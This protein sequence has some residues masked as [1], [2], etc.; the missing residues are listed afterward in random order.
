MKDE[1]FP[2]LKEVDE[3]F[4]VD[5]GEDMIVEKKWD[6]TA[7]LV[8]IQGDDVRILGRGMRKDGSRQDYTGK[9]PEITQ[10]FKTFED[11]EILGEI[12]VLDKDGNESF[13]ALQPRLNREHHIDNFAM[14]YPATFI[15]FDLLS[16][17]GEKLDISYKER[18]TLLRNIMRFNH[19][20]RIHLAHPIIFPIQ[21]TILDKIK[22]GGWEGVVIKNVN[23]AYGIDQYKYKPR[24]TQDVFWEGEFVPGKNK[25]EGKV[26]SLTCY[27]YVDGE[28]IC[29]G[30]VSGLT[31]D[32]R[33][34]FT[35]IQSSVSHNNPSVFE[36]KTH[37]VL[38]SGK[39]RYPNFIR[40]RTDKAPSQCIQK[41]RIPTPKKPT[42]SDWL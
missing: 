21:S 35:E 9:F 6:G 19:S 30:N 1:R 20:N 36:V 7:A 10:A 14:K 13:N 12:V 26:G 18:R 8:Q 29:V 23:A 2:D 24:L 28:K 38:V 17:E 40:E 34:H 16:L 42:L 39:F 31:D 25:N 41:L 32:D 5:L 4:L 37:E 22:E 15:I 33:Q 27:Q 11:A 3:D